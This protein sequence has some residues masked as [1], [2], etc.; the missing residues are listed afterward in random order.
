MIVNLFRKLKLEIHLFQQYFT[1]HTQP[2]KQAKSTKPTSVQVT[3][4]HTHHMLNNSFL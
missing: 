3:P 2:L 4:K 1:P